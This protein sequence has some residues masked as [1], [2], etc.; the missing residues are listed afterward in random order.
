[1]NVTQRG[2]ET[3]SD[4]QPTDL[5]MPQMHPGRK[6]GRHPPPKTRTLGGRVGFWNVVSGLKPTEI[7]WPCAKGR[8]IPTPKKTRES[9][10]IWRELK[11][12][13][14]LL[15]GR[16]N[17]GQLNLSLSYDNCKPNKCQTKGHHFRVFQG[18][19]WNYKLD[20][21]LWVPLIII[22]IASWKSQKWRHNK[23]WRI[24]YI[25]E[26]GLVWPEFHF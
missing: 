24:H 12:L 11:H 26:N 21:T 20:Y 3:S 16:N 1:M 25:C 23:H 7:W 6:T 10:V 5:R 22:R 14:I 17:G 13:R 19:K 4:T 9:N 8:D 2:D 18:S 15:F